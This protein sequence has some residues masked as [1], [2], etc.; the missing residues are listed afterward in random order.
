MLIMS[1]VDMQFIRDQYQFSCQTVDQAIH[2]SSINGQI[3]IFIYALLNKVIQIVMFVTTGKCN[4]R[5]WI[6]S[7]VLWYRTKHKI[8]RADTLIVLALLITKIC[9]FFS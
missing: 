3:Y 8:C 7:P 9:L 2:C 5:Q 6:I 1:M 4:I